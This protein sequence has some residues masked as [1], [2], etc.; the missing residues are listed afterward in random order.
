MTQADRVFITPPTNSPVS[1]IRPVD[2][3]SRRRFLSQAAAAA[4]G[5]AVLAL[6]EVSITQVGAASASLLEP[7][8]SLIE[9]HRTACLAHLASLDDPDESVSEA[10]CHAEWEAFDLLIATAP[11]TFPGLL[12]W[13]AYLDEIRRADPWKFEDMPTASTTLILTL[14]VAFSNLAVSS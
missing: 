12:A 8:F 2:D 4:T 10:P 9:A 14:T 3:P 5:G 13:I 7:V 11:V 6:A 1:Q